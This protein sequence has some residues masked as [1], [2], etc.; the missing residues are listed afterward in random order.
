MKSTLEKFIDPINIPKKY[1][2]QL[3]FEFGHFP[4]VDPAIKNHIQFQ[5]GLSDFPQGPKYW[6]EENGETKEQHRFRCIAVGSTDEVQRQQEVCTVT[7]TFEPIV[8]PL[9]NAERGLGSELLNV[10]T[11]QNSTYDLSATQTE[12]HAVPSLPVAAAAS[13]EV[14]ADKSGVKLELNN[15]DDKVA[16]D[17]S[18]L[19][20]P[21]RPEAERFVTAQENLQTLSLDE[22][23]STPQTNG[24]GS[25][26]F[27]EKLQEG[28]VPA[29]KK[30]DV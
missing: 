3:D 22:K 24:N 21:S 30:L 4:T 12:E 2:G 17:K 6:I 20:P 9:S 26:V 19:T 7:R 13:T 25:T 16:V 5:D 27:V 1:G 28:V 29:L 10:P 23:K 8:P 14:P 11:A 15:G 18:Q